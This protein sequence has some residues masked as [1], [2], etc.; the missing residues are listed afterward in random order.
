MLLKIK[1]LVLVIWSKKNDYNTKINE[2][3][4]KITDDNHDNYS[5]IPEFNKLTSANLVNKTDYD[6]SLNLLQLKQNM[7]LLKMN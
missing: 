7:Y 2:T 4:K 6:D 5:T 1:Y 3:E